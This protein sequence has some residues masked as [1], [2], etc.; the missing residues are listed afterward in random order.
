MEMED[1]DEDDVG[2][3][4][5]PWVTANLFLS[6]GKIHCARCDLSVRNSLSPKSIEMMCRVEE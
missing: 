6:W 1:G 3:P 4:A 2:V 5:N